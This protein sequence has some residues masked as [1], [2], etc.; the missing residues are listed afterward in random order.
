MIQRTYKFLYYWY[1]L[2]LFFGPHTIASTTF[3]PQIIYPSGGT[4][5]ISAA[6][7]DFNRDGHLDIVIL[8]QSD[9]ITDGSVSIFL[10][11]GDGTFT[12]TN[13]YT[14][15]LSPQ[16][17]V[18]ADFNR[19]GLLDLVIL[20]SGDN[21]FTL[22]QG[23][24]DGTFTAQTTTP[25]SN[26]SSFL[27]QNDFNGDGITDVAVAYKSLS[28][29]ANS[30]QVF[31]GNG[32]GI[33]LPGSLFAVD[34]DPAS[35]VT[36][37]FN[38]DGIPDIAAANSGS[39]T[40]SV[41]LGNGDGSFQPQQ[42]YAVGNNPQSIASGVFSNSGFSD[43]VVANAN[44]ASVSVLN[45]NGDGSFQ[46]QVTYAVGNIPSCVALG[47]LNNIGV[48]DIVV[49]NSA[50]NNISVLYNGNFSAQQIFPVGNQPSFI[51]LGDLVGNGR[52]DVI[53]TNFGDNTFSILFNVVPQTITFPPIPNLFF[54]T[55]PFTP[56]ASASS[57]LPAAF[58]V[59]SG[60]A[61]ISGNTLTLTNF[62]T[63]VIAANQSGNDEFAAAPQVTQ[64][65]EVTFKFDGKVTHNNF[66]TQTDI[67]NQLS[68]GPNP[69]PSIT[70]FQLFRNGTFLKQFPVAGPFHY[71]D[72]N[73]KKKQT[74]TYVLN[75]INAAGTTVYS[76]TVVLRD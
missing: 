21:N 57:N 18:A 53:V 17:I 22:L 74:N 30:V 5:P 66:L 75:A 12:L 63:I 16:S 8:N 7:G 41:L 27:I 44:D 67:I 11:N 48:D 54:G 49:S 34:T 38:G 64:S 24:G 39:G 42:D 4:N 15:G 36:A 73:R 72:H 2:L 70:F 61:T 3:N 33:F 46:P 58:S 14:V 35:L 69:N 29:S 6:L 68:W 62:G 51:I 20:N 60:P 45:G 25:I 32:A 56:Y 40:A 37:D 19:D 31:F 76:A 65:F 59:I 1:L 9:G 47:D 55:P 28:T 23:N 43:L 26:F 50:D 52:S 13:T 10:N 71:D